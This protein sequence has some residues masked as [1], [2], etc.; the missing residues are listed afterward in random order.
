[1]N[2][3]DDKEIVKYKTDNALDADIIATQ[4][5]VKE[6]E[7]QQ[8]HKFDPVKFL[9]QTKEQDMDYGETQSLGE[10]AP[11]YTMPNAIVQEKS[12]AKTSVKSQ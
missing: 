7:G 5:H 9:A 8:G 2:P 6:Q 11:Q 3:S 1:M 10:F 12:R 4:K